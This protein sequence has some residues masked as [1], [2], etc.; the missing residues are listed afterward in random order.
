MREGGVERKLGDH[1]GGGV[2]RGAKL[3]WKQLTGYELWRWR[4]HV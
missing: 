1:C 2:V 3:F 4:E